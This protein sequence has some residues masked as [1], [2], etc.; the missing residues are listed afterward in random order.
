MSI[1]VK[2][3]IIHHALNFLFGHIFNIRIRQ[4][5]TIRNMLINSYHQTQHNVTI[6]E[7]QQDCAHFCVQLQTN[8]KNQSRFDHFISLT[9]L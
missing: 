5:T 1:R 2:I 8:S 4:L 6:Q 9:G 7:Q 3:R